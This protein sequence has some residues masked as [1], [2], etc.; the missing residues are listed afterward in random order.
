MEINRLLLIAEE[1]IINLIL[2]LQPTDV[3]G[4]F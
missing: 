4:F 3:F 2:R 1:A